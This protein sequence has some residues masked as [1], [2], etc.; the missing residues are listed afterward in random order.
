MGNLLSEWGKEH[1]VGLASCAVMSIMSVTLNIGCIGCNFICKYFQ[2][3]ANEYHTPA[4]FPSSCHTT[5]F[6]H[7]TFVWEPSFRH[8]VRK[9]AGGE[10]SHGPDKKA[11]KDKREEGDLLVLFYFFSHVV[12]GR[13]KKK[14]SSSRNLHLEANSYSSWEIAL[15]VSSMDFRKSHTDFDVLGV[16]SRTGNKFPKQECRLHAVSFSGPNSLLWNTFHVLHRIY[17]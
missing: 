5:W 13:K 17:I 3:V 7:P 8:Q 10:K 12:L 6:S 16:Y 14:T 9:A 15:C 4:D 11:T 2:E 1:G